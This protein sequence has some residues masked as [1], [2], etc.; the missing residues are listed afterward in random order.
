MAAVDDLSLAAGFPQATREQ[1]LKLVEG[2]LKGA[3]FQKKLAGT[4]AGLSPVAIASLPSIRTAEPF[5]RLRDLS[6][7]Y[8][9]K[10]GARPKVFLAN[11]G[12]IAAFTA[13]ATFAK[14]LLEAGGIEAITNDGFPSLHALTAAFASSGS[15]GACICSS[16]EV[17][18]GP[19]EAA[20]I[21][22]DTAVEDAARDFKKAGGSLVYMVGRPILREDALHSAGVHDFIY[23]GCDLL[24]VNDA[25]HSAVDLNEPDRGEGKSP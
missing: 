2:V 5:E 14:N 20:I 1:G 24:A 12:S 23:S 10:T 11:L 25:I 19:S 18:F 9:A 8:L 3:D 13:R 4:A 15:Q 6:D 16:D 7:A 17:Y 21:P 22:S